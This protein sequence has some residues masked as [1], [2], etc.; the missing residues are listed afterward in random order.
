[1]EE[2]SFSH[3]SLGKLKE[4]AITLTNF[5][6]NNC[7]VIIAERNSQTT[8]HFVLNAEQAQE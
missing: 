7:T 3:V 1:L 6:E 2:A 4:K 8:P 5:G